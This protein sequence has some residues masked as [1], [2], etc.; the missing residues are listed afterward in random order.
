MGMVVRAIVAAA[1]LWA[2]VAQAAPTVFTGVDSD[3]SPPVTPV[4]SL[5]VS[6][7]FFASLA[8]SSQVSTFGTQDFESVTPPAAGQDLK[9][10]IGGVNA[11]LKSADGKL[12]SG[13][14][15]VNSERYSVPGG[16]SFWDV[17]SGTSFEITFDGLV[18]AFSFWGTDIGE[19]GGSLTM[20]LLDASG[21]IVGDRIAVNT[22]DAQLGNVLFWGVI[23]SSEKEFFKTVRF[24]TNQP[25][26]GK[27]VFG[28]DTFTVGSTTTGGTVPEPASLALVGLALAG[29][30]AARRRA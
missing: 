24:T 15:G 6:D 21:N 13:P 20:E 2:G 12:V 3:L 25:A 1:A 8:L 28:F 29:L 9:V 26:T 17:T 18:S 4:N 22:G 27:D 30:G 7:A 23:A 11:T 10:A 19:S 5:A 14:Q 16:S